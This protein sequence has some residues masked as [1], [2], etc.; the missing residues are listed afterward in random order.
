M[1]DIKNIPLFF[2]IGRPRSGTTLLRFFIDAHPNVIIPTETTFIF[3]LYKKYKNIRNWNTSII[4]NFT[5]DLA[6]TRF[7]KLA[8]FDADEIR[9]VLMEYKGKLDFQTACKITISTYESIFPKNEIL[10][11][12][13]KNPDY[14]LVF[15]S[16]F[17]IF[18]DA[19]YIHL[20]RDPRDTYIS[21]VNA[22]FGYPSMA[23]SAKRWKTSFR[24]IENLKN[25]YPDKFLTVKFEDLLND[26][27]GILKNICNF[28]S[29]PYRSEMINYLEHKDDFTKLY[30]SKSLE[31]THKSISA[32]I[33][34]S[35]AGQWST[36]L[37]EREIMI[38]DWIAGPCYKKAGYIRKYNQITLKNRI[39]AFSGLLL[40]YFLRFMFKFYTILPLRAQLIIIHNNH[41]INK[42][43][44]KIFLRK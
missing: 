4:S 3:Q 15:D 34:K 41:H 6:K 39:K 38:A 10:V 22:N 24:Y 18:Q 2:I 17:G 31:S 23:V 20:I 16:I 28:V 13:D 14:S 27:E 11:L 42:I 26:T 32:P 36:K 44:R 35:K 43:F 21:A 7:Y 29:I 5:K 9:S 8:K 25:T 12:G 40:Y 19:K 37:S 33:D 1:P 30:P